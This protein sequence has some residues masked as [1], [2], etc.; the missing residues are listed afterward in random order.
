MKAIKQFIAE[1]LINTEIFEMAQSLAEYKNDI[2]NYLSIILC[3]IL[4]I[5]KANEENSTEYIDHWKHEIRNFLRILVQRK[6]KTKDNYQIRKKHIEDILIRR[7][8]LDTNDN[9]IWDLSNKLFKEGYDLDDENIYNNF[10]NLFHKFQEEYLDNMIDVLADKD[11]NKIKEFVN[12][13]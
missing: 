12:K 13:L 9:Y 7:Y 10:I 11:I 1:H 2:N 5:M 4:L 3:H 8:E 6:L